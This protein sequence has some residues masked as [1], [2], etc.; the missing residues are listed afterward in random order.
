[1]SV[2]LVDANR[3]LPIAYRNTIAN[4][5]AEAEALNGIF[6][7]DEITYAWYRAKGIAELPYPPF[8][9][10]ADAR[11]RDR[12]DDRSAR[13]DAD[14]R[15]AVQPRQRVSGRRGRARADHVRQGDDRLVHQRQLRRSAGG[16]ARRPRGA[17]AGR[18]EDREGVRRVSGIGRRRAADRAARCAARRRVDRRRVPL[19]RRRRSG[20]RGAAR[21]SARGRTRSSKGQRA[22]TSF[23]RNWQNRMG[24]G[25]EGYL[26]SP[27]VVAASALLGYMA[28]P[29]ELGPRRGT[30]RSSV[31]D[32]LS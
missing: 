19:G 5:M 24:L 28:P 27:V 3:Q 25:G 26:A 13:R 7:P 16:G 22:I 11:L 12:R 2:E 6:A 14:D 20:S 4:M 32:G 15:E 29:S 18:D 21:A 8:A 30:R 1:M 10:G 9:P 17:R 23:N 31:S